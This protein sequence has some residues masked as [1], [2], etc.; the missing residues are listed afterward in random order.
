MNRYIRTLVA[1]SGLLFAVIIP[2]SA[3]TTTI[4][5]NGLPGANND[6]FSTFTENGYTV[7]NS[8]GQ[9]FVGELYGNPIPDIFAGPAYGPATDA[10]TVTAGGATFSLDQFDL[11]ANNGATGYTLSGSLNG[12]SVFAV[13]GTDSTLDAFITENPGLSADVIDSLTLQFTGS[14]TSF[15]VDN[16]VLSTATATPE[17]GSLALFA[18]AGLGIATA[19]RRRYSSV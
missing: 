11:S 5:F 14:G 15:N 8:Q 9:F 18:T 17:P 13:V 19:L 4:D 1:A 10:I 2:A 12:S 7:T 3:A 6:P 16:I